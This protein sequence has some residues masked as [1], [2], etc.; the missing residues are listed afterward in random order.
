MKTQ[1]LVLSAAGLLFAANHVQAAPADSEQFAARAATKADSL[2][3]AA[4]V[5]PKAQ[6]V[7][8]RA[9]V[10]PDGR[11]SGVRVVRS[12]GSRDTDH[13][14][15]TVLKKILVA[16]PPVGLVDGAVTLNL[17]DARTGQATAP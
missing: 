11:L 14:V 8:V 4:G 16:D 3:I 6:S 17:G 7:A 2:L 13:A 5:D 15:A 12:S 10:S 1:L 9:S